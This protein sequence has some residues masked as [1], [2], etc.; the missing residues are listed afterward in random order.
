MSVA[1]VTHLP[2]HEL[3]KTGFPHEEDF[4]AVAALK[5]LRIRRLEEVLA[6]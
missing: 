4:R 6:D 5:I 2:I 1:H 3:A